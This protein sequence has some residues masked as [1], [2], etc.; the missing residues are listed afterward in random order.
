ML[1]P[2]FEPHAIL[3][4]DMV[5]YSQWLAHQPLLTHSVFSNHL[6]E[7][8]LPAVRTHAGRFIKTTGDGIVAIFRDPVDAEECARDIQSQIEL[9]DID[10]P[11]TTIVRYRVCVHF[12]DVIVE[13]NDVF[14]IDVNAAIHMQ[15]LAPRGGICVSGDLFLRL[16]SPHKARYQYKG[17]KYLKNIPYPL[18]I[19]HY[20]KS[21]D[22]LGAHPI[23]QQLPV[24]RRSFL[25]PPPRLGLAALRIHTR[26]KS[27]GVLAELVRE[28]LAGG[29]SR[30]RDVLTVVPL[31]AVLADSAKVA[32]ARRYL[33]SDLGLE[34]IVHGSMFVDQESMTL[35][36]R[37]DCL[38]T[39]SMIWFHRMTFS[40]K[41]INDVDRTVVDEFVAPLILYLQRN[42]IDSWNMELHSEEENLFHQAQQLVGRGTLTA[43]DQAKLL[44][45]DIVDRCGEIGDV[46]IELARA[47]HSRGK[48]LAGEQFVEALERARGYAKTAIEL[49]D[50]NPRA[51]AEYALQEVFLRRHT[52][53][54]QIYE[55]AL[56]LNPYDPMLQADWGDC[57]VLM[58]RA[59]E[60]LPILE[61]ALAGWPRDRR[62]VEWNLCDAE[63]ALGRP[64]RIIEILSHQP[65]QPH[66]H[67]YL[68]ASHARMGNLAEAT[69]H[70]D[71]VLAHQ[72]NF[73]TKAWSQVVP[74][75]RHDTAE[76]YA[77]YLARAGL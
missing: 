19:Y 39:T 72:P 38:R 77:D 35:L 76:E 54:A 41:D 14:G 10:G 4:A 51:H 24:Y 60:A 36:M 63:W 30:F 11:S 2:R 21:A 22:S 28:S 16:D 74:H 61:K 56:R 52:H 55:R 29:L 25:S 46:Y 43:I 71:K 9:A 7:I 32:E 50:L 26:V 53:A 40:T 1:H 23:R 64:E 69:R 17:Q 48:L 18:A 67:R 6:H 49:D 33:E 13:P 44:L 66:V 57:L 70:A 73:S 68:A 45:S 27:H 47:E 31:E 8:F 15:S 65:D 37:M 34:Y 20:R 58:G 12:G 42:E 5:G 59:A 75:T 62:W 3:V